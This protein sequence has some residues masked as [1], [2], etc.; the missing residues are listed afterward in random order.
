[1]VYP[2]G[3]PGKSWTD[4]EKAAWLAQRVQRRSY[5]EEVLAKLE[6]LKAQFDVFQY[7]ALSMDPSRYPLYAIKSRK[8]AAGKPNVL[9]TGGVHGYET[10]GVQGALLF[11]ATEM[12]KYEDTFNII[13]APCV[14]PWGYEHIERWT[15]KAVDPNRAFKAEMEDRAEEAVHLIAM[16]G[17]LNVVSWLAHWDLHE[18][19]DTDASEFCPAKAARDGEEYKPE[20]IPDGF[21]LVGNSEAPQSEWHTAMIESVKQ[22][23]HIAPPDADGLIIGE[24]VPQ[25]GCVFCPTKTLGL[26]AG[27]TNAAYSTTTEVYPDSPKATPEQCNR[28]QVA[29]V[30][31]GL[32]YLKKAE[33]KL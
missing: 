16:L 1:M 15:A 21:Y 6:G 28:A 10:S 7:G 29:S 4:A 31:G 30:T 22:V 25:E 18:T 14:S 23:T 24:A 33:L 2:I 26:C 32:E 27:V 5:A 11:A 9:V 8:W 13:V 17:Q 20:V 12:A 19:T 3:T